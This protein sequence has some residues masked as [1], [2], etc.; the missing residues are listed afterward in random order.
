M[1]KRRAQS[2]PREWPKRKASSSLRI[3]PR[4]RPRVVA[5][6]CGRMTIPKVNEVLEL[7]A[8]TKQFAA[9]RAVDDVSLVLARGEFFSLVGPSGCGKTTM[10]RMV[11]GF[12]IPSSG[13]I[14][15]DGASVTGI[16]P[17]RRNVSTV[18]Q[19]YALFPHLTARE[20]VAFGL[21]RRGKWTKSEIRGK[22]DRVLGTVQLSGKESR[23]PRELSGGEKQ[24]V[25]LARSLVLEPRV[26]LLDEPLSALDPQIRKQIR[27]DLK[28][29][30]RKVGITFLFI[31]H[32]QEEAMAVSDRMAV[33]KAGRIIQVG[34]PDTLYRRTNS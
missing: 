16:P 14:F 28:E 17:Y 23:Y 27:Q 3:R 15:L 33:M 2:S 31:T 21:A 12:E 32:D 34:V 4:S 22:V 19:S 13:E 29:L 1:P 26:L 20:N 10:L 9:Q 24:R 25:A 18:F 5:G 7:R 6:L 11:A 8:V 30:Q